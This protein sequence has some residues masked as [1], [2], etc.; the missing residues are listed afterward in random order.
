MG[1]HNTNTPFASELRP[2]WDTVIWVTFRDNYPFHKSN[3]LAIQCFPEDCLVLGKDPWLVEANETGLGDVAVKADDGGIYVHQGLATMLAARALRPSF[4]IRFHDWTWLTDQLHGNNRLSTFSDSNGQPRNAIM[5]IHATTEQPSNMSEV[6]EYLRELREIYDVQV[7]PYP[8]ET[9]WSYDQRKIGDIRALDRI[10]QST[11]QPEYSYR[12]QTCFGQDPCR[13]QHCEKTVHKRLHS[14]GGR[15]VKVLGKGICS[16]LTYASEQPEQGRRQRTRVIRPYWFHQEFVPL[17]SRGEFRVIIATKPDKSGI[18]GRS[19]Y[20]VASAWTSWT[21]SNPATRELAVTA[22]DENDFGGSANSKC[23]PLCQTDLEGFCLYIFEKLRGQ[24]SPCYESLEVGARMDVGVAQDRG[25]TFFF[26]NEVTR[27]YNAHYF[28]HNLL[29]EPKTKICK[30]FATAFVSY[31]HD[32][33]HDVI[34]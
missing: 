1:Q 30:A 24:N 4:P 17:L 31:V 33:M 19:G 34:H 26:V 7:R 15:H 9:E 8:S 3:T 28:S 6:F 14:E 22:V 27:W 11:D 12:P 25:Q 32:G 20:V 2:S 23:G 5:F 13:L 18:R 10:A 29:P 16:A 21:S